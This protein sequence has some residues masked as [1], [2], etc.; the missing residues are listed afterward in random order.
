LQ[1]DLR[2]DHAVGFW[3]LIGKGSA[4]SCCRGD[5]LGLRFL[6]RS[7]PRHV[8]QGKGLIISPA[9]GLV[10]MIQKVDA[11]ARAGGRGLARSVSRWCASR[12][13]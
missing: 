3:L 7:D 2:R 13:S 10:T 9:D 5:H 1:S 6:P 11:A 8:P 4:G 12:F